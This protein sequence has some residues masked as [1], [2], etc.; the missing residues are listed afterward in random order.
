MSA[1]VQRIKGLIGSKK[2]VVVSKS[3]CGFCRKAKVSSGSVG[4]CEFPKQIP[5]FLHS[6]A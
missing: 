3:W 1:G 6:R 5:F 2:V 4:K